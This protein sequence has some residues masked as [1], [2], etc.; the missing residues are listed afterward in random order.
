VSFI[1]FDTD[2]ENLFSEIPVPAGGAGEQGFLFSIEERFVVVVE[3][4]TQCISSPTSGTSSDSAR[5]C[6]FQNAW[7]SAHLSGDR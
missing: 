7:R 4:S 6:Q 1:S 5:Q 3:S 2:L